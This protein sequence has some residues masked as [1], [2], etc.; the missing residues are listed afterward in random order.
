MVLEELFTSDCPLL[1]QLCLVRHWLQ[2]GLNYFKP[3]LSAR[4]CASIM[5]KVSV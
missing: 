5:C 4:D 1:M 3:T 2:H